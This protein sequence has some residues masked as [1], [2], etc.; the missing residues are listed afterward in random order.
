MKYA[1]LL[2]PILLTSC[3]A[4]VSDLNR[5]AVA[6]RPYDLNKLIEKDG[7]CFKYCKSSDK[8]NVEKLVLPIYT[9]Q[10]NLVVLD[11]VLLQKKAASTDWVQKGELW[12][13]VE[14]PGIYEKV[15][16]LRDTL[17]FRDFKYKTFENK[18]MSKR[19]GVL[20]L[21]EIVCLENQDAKLC[22][23]ISLAL[24]DKG[25]IKD[26]TATNDVNFKTAT[27]KYI[28]DNNLPK[29]VISIALLDHLGVKQ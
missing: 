23:K 9:G 27:K 5:N 10:D 11:S 29:D 15:I 28:D 18:G 2:L 14:K 13:L 12:C 4:I 17:K 24:R 25:Y 19:G 16:Y 21:T 7:K 20:E 6:D 3:A 22:M 1:L 26:I 8:Y